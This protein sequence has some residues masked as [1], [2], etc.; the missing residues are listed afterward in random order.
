MSQISSAKFLQNAV[1]G[2]SKVIIFSKRSQEREQVSWITDSIFQDYS[3]K[4]EKKSEG[5]HDGLI[6]IYILIYQY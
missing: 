3:C 5:E 2:G 1:S 6:Q 4:R